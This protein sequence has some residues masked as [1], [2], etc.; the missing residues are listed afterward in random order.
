MQ[1]TKLSKK[2]S[3]WNHSLILGMNIQVKECQEC[4]FIR[5]SLTFIS[6]T[7][8]RNSSLFSTKIPCLSIHL[9]G[10]LSFTQATLRRGASQT[11]L[12]GAATGKILLVG[13]WGFTGSQIG[14]KNTCWDTKL[15]YV[16]G[17]PGNINNTQQLVIPTMAHMAMM[18]KLRYQYQTNAFLVI[19]SVVKSILAVKAGSHIME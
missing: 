4:P 15:G 13:I 10:V 2:E 9:L 16:W 19:S 12:W 1:E 17:I 18:S 11:L 7:N 8:F 14:N 5:F 6:T 3:P